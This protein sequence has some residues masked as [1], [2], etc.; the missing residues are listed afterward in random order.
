MSVFPQ[1]HFTPHISQILHKL[2]QLEEQQ[3]KYFKVLQTNK[4]GPKMN[5][6]KNI[7]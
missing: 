1:E 5:K 6:P 7:Y 3:E 2:I 4:S